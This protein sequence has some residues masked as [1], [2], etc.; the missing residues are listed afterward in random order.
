[1]PGVF[2]LGSLL[3]PNISGGSRGL[4]GAPYQ[5]SAEVE[6][7]PSKAFALRIKY[8]GGKLF[9][10]RFDVV[11]V[12]V[13]LALSQHFGI[14][15]RYGYASY[16]DTAFGDIN[17]NYW[18]AGVSLNDVLKRGAIAG[19]A[20]GQPFIEG[21]GNATQINMEAFYNYPVNDNIRLTSLLQVITNPGNQSSNGTIVTGTLRTIFSF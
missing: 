5:H 8:S 14:F 4:F 20:V 21:A 2:S 15:G 18:M 12:N 11:G 19:V 7:A 16:Q 1:M 3:Y 10:G 17:P 13:E 9:A 6:Y